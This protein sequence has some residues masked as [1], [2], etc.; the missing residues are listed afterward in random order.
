LDKQLKAM[1]NFLI[2]LQTG[3]VTMVLGSSTLT[4]TGQA[5]IKGTVYDR[6]QHI[7]IQG[8][9]LMGTSGAGTMTD[10]AGRYRLRLAFGDSL[11]CSYLGKS[12]VQ[13][14]PSVSV[15]EPIID[16]YG[17]SLKNRAYQK[18]FDHEVSNDLGKSFSE[19]WKEQHPE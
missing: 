18:I 17:D 12:T 11:Y 15:V 2:F 4:V 14:L 8:V 13:S 1:K 3:I 7:P 9:S 10:S 16:Y 19:I 5:L 6:S